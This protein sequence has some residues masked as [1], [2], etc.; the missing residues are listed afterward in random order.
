MTALWIAALLQGALAAE[1]IAQVAPVEV[2]VFAQQARV[3]RKATVDL[4]AGRQ[5]VRFV[6]L[7]ISAD[8]RS[9]TADVTGGAELTGIDH[10]RVTARDVADARVQELEAKLLAL[11]DQRQAAADDVASWDAE[12]AALAHARGEAGKALSAQLLVGDKAPERA[13]ALRA[14]LSAEDAK[15]RDAR[16]L[17]AVRVRDLD[18]QIGALQRERDGLGSGVPDTYD[19]I[20][21]VE[22]TKPTRVTVS[23]DYLVG[24][25]GWT[26]QYDLRGDG[27]GKVA[28]SLSALVTQST[29]EDWSQV[30]LAVSSARPDRG[31]TVPLLD[32]FW[33]QVWR[34]PPRP[35]PAPA[36]SAP[37]R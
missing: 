7:P 14:S 22:L 31:T 15:A 6:G 13:R 3:T 35:M 19:A 23:L 12:I 30:K 34:P 28:M 11:R 4:P 27:S 16:R 32:P 33:L 2:T 20:V 8:P 29:G 25:A 5:D 9:F 1:Q 36:A 26:P 17:A 21:H 37:S 10:K 24:G 18:L